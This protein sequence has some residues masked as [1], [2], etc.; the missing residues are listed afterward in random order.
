MPFKGI[1]YL[2][3]WQAFCSVERNHLYN[4]GRSYYD[5]Q[6]CEIILNFDQWYWRRCCL[7]IFLSVAL[8][9]LLFVGAE[10]FMQF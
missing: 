6:L 5:K 10:P 9:E 1:T 7:K 4:F 3:P 2:E 8:V